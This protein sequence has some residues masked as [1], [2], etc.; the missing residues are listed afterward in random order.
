MMKNTRLIMAHA[1]QSYIWNQAAT[2]RVQLHGLQCVVGDLVPVNSSGA[3]VAVEDA[4]LDATLVEAADAKTA[5]S[6]NSFQSADKNKQGDIHTVTAEDVAAGRFGIH[7]VI[8]P[9]PGLNVI[10]PRNE[11]GEF[12]VFLSLHCIIYPL[13]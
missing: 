12:A 7:D 6:S 8:L 11:I 9:L 10:L 3:A 4:G 13:L 2:R 1:Y 5:S